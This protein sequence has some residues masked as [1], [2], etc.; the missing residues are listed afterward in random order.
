MK[1]PWNIPNLPVYSVATY[2]KNGE[3]NMNIA[4]YVTAVSMQPK[5]IAVALYLGTKSFDNMLLDEEIV[6]QLLH[7]SQYN[8]VKN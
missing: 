3:V 1:R 2:D 4:T 7:R 6:L 5:K 8:L